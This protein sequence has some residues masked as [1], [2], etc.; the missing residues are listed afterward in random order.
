MCVKYFFV[1]ILSP[2][3]NRYL[4]SI[5]NDMKD[6]LNEMHNYYYVTLSIFSQFSLISAASIGHLIAPE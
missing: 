2:L 4:F 5:Q 6:H 1:L 3:F